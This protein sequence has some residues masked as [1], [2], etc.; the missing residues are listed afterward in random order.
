MEEI[1]GY[2]FDFDKRIYLNSPK[3]KFWEVTVNDADVTYRAG[4][5]RG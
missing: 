1:K 5:L 2:R 4:V 3:S